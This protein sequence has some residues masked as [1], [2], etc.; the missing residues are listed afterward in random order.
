[1]GAVE[2]CIALNIRC[3]CYDFVS[4]RSHRPKFLDVGGIEFKEVVTQE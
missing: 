1:M 2:E 4:K 3:Y